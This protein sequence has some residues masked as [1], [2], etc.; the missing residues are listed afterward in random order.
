MVPLLLIFTSIV[1]IL[2]KLGIY[3]RNNGVISRALMSNDAKKTTRRFS[4]EPSTL[5]PFKAI[6]FL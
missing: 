2:H 3:P 5:I 4:G 1:K 6:F